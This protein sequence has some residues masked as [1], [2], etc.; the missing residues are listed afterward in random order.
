MTHM[1]N[2]ISSEMAKDAGLPEIS[3]K[4]QIC[5]V[6]PSSLSDNLKKKPNVA[7][8]LTFVY[9][10]YMTKSYLIVNIHRKEQCHTV[11]GH[12]FTHAFNTSGYRYGRPFGKSLTWNIYIQKR[13]RLLS[14]GMTRSC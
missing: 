9:K 3:G 6:N 5:L 10:K 4:F 1:Y 11:R 14:Q 7:L 13:Y 8:L 12:S 2:E